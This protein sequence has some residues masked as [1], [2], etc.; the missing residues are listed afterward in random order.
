MTQG[1]CLVSPEMHEKSGQMADACASWCTAWSTAWIQ[2]KHKKRVINCATQQRASCCLWRCN[3]LLKRAGLLT[4]LFETRA[5]QGGLHGPKM[6]ACESQ[7]SLIGNAHWLLHSESCS[8]KITLLCDLNT[9]NTTSFVSIINN[10]QGNPTFPI[11]FSMASKS[12]ISGLV[13]PPKQ[14]PM[15]F[16]L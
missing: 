10:K 8:S 11:Y 1:Q 7:T 16:F 9:V 4:I 13:E 12:D 6:H 5:A 2:N 15:N 14:W 3:T